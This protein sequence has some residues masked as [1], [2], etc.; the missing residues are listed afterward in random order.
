MILYHKYKITD[1]VVISFVFSSWI[2]N[3]FW[4]VKHIDSVLF[5]QRGLSQEDA[6]RG[7]NVAAAKEAT[8]QLAS[9]AHVHLDK[10]RYILFVLTTHFLLS[11]QLMLRID[12]HLARWPSNCPMD[13]HFLIDGN[14]Q[15]R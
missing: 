6:L 4:V 8:Y 9:V 10:V 7:K 11:I 15:T 14:S 13:G 5:F 2:I 3:D 1:T 12:S